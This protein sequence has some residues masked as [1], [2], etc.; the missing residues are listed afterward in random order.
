M[1]QFKC[2]RNWARNTKGDILEQYE[3]NRI[4][5]E[6]KLTHFEVYNEPST[7]VAT[8]VVSSIS[9]VD[10]KPVLVKAE[11]ETPAPVAPAEPVNPV[12]SLDR[13][14]DGDRKKIKNA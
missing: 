7:V 10:V 2:I 1:A 9:T 8:P 14:I 6:L 11:T 4:P 13:I 12:G 5:Q 3:Y